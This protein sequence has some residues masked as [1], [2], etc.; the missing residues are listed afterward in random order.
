MIPEVRRF[1][2]LAEASRSLAAYLTATICADAAANGVCSLALTGG[3]TPQTLYRELTAP[4]LA[5]TMPWPLLHLFWGDERLVPHEHPASNYALAKATLLD[6]VPLP[7]TNIHAIATDT[8]SAETAAVRYEE[9]LRGFF[10]APPEGAAG[11]PRFDCIL[12]GMG[13]DGHIASLFPGSPLLAEQRRWVV[14]CGPSGSPPLPR[15]TL[16][17]PV[18]NSAKRVVLLISGPQKGCILNEILAAP[19]AAAQRYPAARIRN[20]ATILWFVAP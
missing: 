17:L 6:Q 13:E 18:L 16:T 5:G 4:D 10:G 15:V 20:P 14:A 7:A 1:D 12:L 3:A 8:A 19:E 2:S 9:E 11:F